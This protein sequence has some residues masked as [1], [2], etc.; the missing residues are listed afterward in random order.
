MT[1][2]Q[3][4]LL[5]LRAPLPRRRRLSWMASSLFAMA[6]LALCGGEVWSQT[7]QSM[8]IIVPFA[9]GGGADILA[10][11][12]AEEIARAQKI[13]A[14]VE[15]RP[16]GGT[17]PATEAVAHAAPDGTMILMNANSFVIN[18]S[19]RKLSYDPLTAFEPLCNLVGTPMFIV[20]GRDSPYRT[21]KEL[22]DA[23]RARPGE[24]TLASLGPATAQHIAFELLKRRANVNMTFVAY[25][26]NVPAINA[27][28][29]GHVTSALANFPEIVEQVN[30]GNLRVLA[31]T[32]RARF[33]RLPH[34]Q[35]IAESG[36][37]GYAAEVWL[38]LV[39]PARTPQDTLG[40]IVAWSSAAMQVP[41]IKARL[42][43]L[44]LLPKSMCGPDFAAYMR[45]QR[46]DYARILRDAN[47]K[48]E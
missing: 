4:Y 23:A 28:M 42:E 20:V 7:P 13:P 46:D 1:D 43:A 41:A 5:R 3:G 35:T 15:N 38:G 10:R 27:L 47:I 22:L 32:T 34:T 6:L 26:G 14:V 24:L 31:T 40:R 37:D 29:G 12:L 33:E 18:P 48:G 17:V 16:G 25:S 44:G 9:P 21:L 2:Q 30:A 8:R 45:S 11:L 19:L 39:A 36:F